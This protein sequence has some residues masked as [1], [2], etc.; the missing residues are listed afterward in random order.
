MARLPFYCR[1]LLAHFCQNGDPP[2]DEFDVLELLVDSMIRREHGKRVFQWQDFVDV[3]ALA[4]ALE[5]ELSRLTNRCR[6]AASCRPQSAASSTSKRPSCCSSSLEGW[7]IAF[8]V[9]RM[10]ASRAFPPTTPAIS[11]PSAAR[12]QTATTASCAGCAPRSCGLRSRARPQ[13]RR[14]RFHPRDP[15]R[16][17]RGPLRAVENRDGAACVC[18]RPERQRRGARRPG[19]SANHRQNGGRHR[20][21]RAVLLVPPLLRAPA[22]R[23]IPACVPASHWFWSVAAS[24]LPMS[25]TSWSCCSTWSRTTAGGSRNRRR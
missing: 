19:G 2:R 3:E 21:G 18:G 7:R 6:A 14:P 23:Q 13:G 8:A 15:R 9:C 20:R 11:L 22:G 5:D 12:V 1:V 16:V 25:K 24:T 17:L 10:R 4:Q